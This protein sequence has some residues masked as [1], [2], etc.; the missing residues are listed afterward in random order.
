MN[1]DV[2]IDMGQYAVGDLVGAPRVSVLTRQSRSVNRP[3]SCTY[4]M[5]SGICL[6]KSFDGSVYQVLVGDR[7]VTY[8]RYMLTD[9]DDITSDDKQHT[10]GLVQ[11]WM[12]Q[13]L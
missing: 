10:F 3:V 2:S 6:D 11:E 4:R 5:S 12:K 7:V 1:E 8:P 9:F 13:W